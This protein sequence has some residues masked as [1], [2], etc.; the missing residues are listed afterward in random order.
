MSRPYP[1]APRDDTVEVAGGHVFLHPFRPLE[2]ASDPAV[3]A[4]QREQDK[5]TDAYVAS[6][7]GLARLRARVAH[8]SAGHNNPFEPPAVPRR[9]GG[10]WF[11]L[12]H[13]PGST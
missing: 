10:R 11:R 4:W 6:I 1:P 8:Y 9:A 13:A 3:V 5:R 2:D 7:P 12:E